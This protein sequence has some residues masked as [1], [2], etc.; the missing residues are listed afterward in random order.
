MH[1]SHILCCILDRY[2]TEIIQWTDDSAEAKDRVRTTRCQPAVAD[3]QAQR[4]WRDDGAM[5][6]LKDYS[7]ANRHQLQR[8][9]AELVFYRYSDDIVLSN[10]QKTERIPIE[11]CIISV[12]YRSHADMDGCVKLQSLED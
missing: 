10:D 11:Y 12:S 4:R 3:A 9:D 6:L 8:L 5:V 7:D 2:D 1:L